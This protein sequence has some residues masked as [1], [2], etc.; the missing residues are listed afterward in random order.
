[1]CSICFGFRLGQG[2]SLKSLCVMLLFRNDSP[3]YL[4]DS[5]DWFS[6]DAQKRPLQEMTLI[7]KRVSS[8]YQMGRY[9]QHFIHQS[10]EKQMTFL[11]IGEMENFLYLPY[12]IKHRPN[13]S[14][15]LVHVLSETFSEYRETLL[16]SL[17]MLRVGK[18]LQKENKKKHAFF[19]L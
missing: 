15:H 5:S 19:F 3:H 9:L 7:L 17:K 14:I 12:M 11:L 16:R 1:M 4:K 18:F 8:I 10:I 2:I 13:K 6:L